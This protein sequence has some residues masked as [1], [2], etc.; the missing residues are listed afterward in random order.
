MI[1][2]TLLGGATGTAFACD[3]PPLVAIPAAADVAGREDQ[4]RQEMAA[5]YQA[6]QA[7]SACVQA[8]LEAAG[9]DAAPSLTKTVLINRNNAAVAEVEAVVKLFNEN[10]GPA[11]GVPNPGGN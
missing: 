7:Y 4:I 11:D 10:V 6:M 1:C 8:E 3:M 2:A 5:Y 9:G